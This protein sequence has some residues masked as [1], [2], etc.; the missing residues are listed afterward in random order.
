MKNI[1]ILG[2]TGSVGQQTLDVISKF[3]EKFRI[4]GLAAG[5]NI[6]LLKKQIIKFRPKVVS[7]KDKEEAASLEK[8]FPSANIEFCHSQEGAEAI[9]SFAQVDL[10]VSAMVGASGLRPTL[11]AIKSGKNI[12]LA[13]KEV[14]VMA[15]KILTEEATRMGVTIIPV[16]SEHSAI[17]Q[18]LKNRN[19]EFVKR[20]ILTASGGPLHKTPIEKL[21]DVTLDAALN[22]PTWKM[23]KKIT[24]DSATLM[25]KG[26]E[27]IEAKW[28]F[29]VEPNRI[30]VW[31]H[32]QS[33]VHSMVEY[34]DGSIIAQM[35]PPDMRIP[36]SYALS[37][38][39]RIDIHGNNA[40]AQSFNEL[41]F[42]EVN[43]GK[44]PALGLAYEAIN[45]GGT[46]PAVLNAANEIAVDAFLKG[47]LKFL[48]ILK[49][50]KQAINQHEKLPGD[51]LKEIIET[52]NWARAIARSKIKKLGENMQ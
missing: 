27:V 30:S 48:D 16:D 28:L 8:E 22:H 1:S 49:V 51:N 7:V 52:D 50:V 41:T 47:R 25:N 3:P 35:S 46:T 42:E 14:L 19:M 37:Y 23:G 17:F 24:I 13:N 2:S 32:P 45:H 31:I 40:S 36:I 6:S 21:K 4:L 15:G 20:I 10:V 33:I 9:A 12:A 5:R 29:G 39:E 44:F 38:P 11:A 18:V 43:L 34:I 26:F